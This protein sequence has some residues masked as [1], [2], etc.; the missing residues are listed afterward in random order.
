M[1][2]LF[3]LAVLISAVLLAGCPEEENGQPMQQAISILTFRYDAARDVVIANTRSFAVDGAITPQR[4]ADALAGLPEATYTP[5]ATIRMTDPQAT[6]TDGVLTVNYR[7]VA[8]LGGLSSAQAA[9]AFA[10]LEA[11]W[12]VPGVT[13]VRLQ[14][15]GQPATALGPVA[16]TQPLSRPIHTYVLQ[17]TTGEVGYLT[18][19]LMPADL[20]A[21]LTILRN[22]QISTFPAQQGFTPLLSPNV[23]LTANPNQI[24]NGV[25]TVDLAGNFPRTD[26][27]RL[28]G[29]VL[30]LT[31]F[32]A[33]QAVRFTFGG[34]TINAPIMRSNLNAPLRPYDLLLP[35]AAT[36][37][38]PAVTDAVKT[39]AAKTL[40]TPA[41]FEPA[42][43]WK[44]LA[45]VTTR[46]Q[47]D[48]AP[49]SFLLKGQEG[50]YRVL[51]SGTNLP[52]AELLQQ[53]VPVEA[54]I[55]FRL[56]GW[57]NLSLSE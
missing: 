5:S 33:V 45:L 48:T 28:A 2:W 1:R 56:P 50:T 24:A 19:A 10:A 8:G 52:V 9:A 51:A 11:W 12:W 40:A 36:A 18:G 31:Q 29:I 44:D 41:D 7:D 46:P 16:I 17:P 15:N 55:A 34:E 47:P 23:T 37:A 39:A 13:Q 57:E 53:G 20:P 21:A 4:Y 30:M 54:V 3:L 49:R 22:R 43:V 27:A 25:L 38:S 14:F 42:L 35:A 26:S 6:V 32:P